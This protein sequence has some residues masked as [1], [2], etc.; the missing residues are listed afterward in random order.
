MGILREN[1]WVGHFAM[2]NL[3]CF[4]QVIIDDTFFAFSGC[5]RRQRAGENAFLVKNQWF[6]QFAMGN[7]TFFHQVIMDGSFFAFARSLQRQRAEENTFLVK[8]NGLGI[9]RWE[10]LLVFTRSLWM[11]FF[12]HLRDVSSDKRG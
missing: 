8:T 11:T 2:G 4:H 6:G 7:P 3:T 10:I 12:L 1:Q 5:L 9:S